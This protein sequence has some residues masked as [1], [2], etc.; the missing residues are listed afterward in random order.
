MA[1]V[2]QTIDPY[3][4]SSR[5][6]GEILGAAAVPLPVEVLIESGP[7][8]IRKLYGTLRNWMTKKEGGVLDAQLRRDGG[9]RIFKA[10]QASEEYEGPE[11]I[12]AL[13]NGLIN[14]DSSLPRS[15]DEA[16]NI[17]PESPSKAA[18]IYNLP[19]ANTLANIETSL[20]KRN[21]ELQV[22]A[23]KGKEQLLKN[24][25]AAIEILA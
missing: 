23:Q 24:A 21:K 1:L 11:Q 20:S 12:E 22:T 15:V 7:N 18:R 4:E 9:T 19:L 10:L 3:D 25:K 6:I 17:V 8:V 2:A 13:I 14:G 5:F 16:G